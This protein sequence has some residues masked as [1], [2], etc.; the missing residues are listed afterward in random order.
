MLLIED[1]AGIVAQ[2]PRRHCRRWVKRP[3]K[4]MNRTSLPEC[5]AFFSPKRNRHAGF[6]GM[7]SSVCQTLGRHTVVHGGAK[8]AAAL[9]LLEK[10]RH[11]QPIRVAVALQEEILGV[12][13]LNA[14]HPHSGDFSRAVVAAAK[15]A[16]RAQDFE[17][18]IIAIGGRRLVLIWHSRP[19]RV[20]RV[21]AVE[22]MSPASAMAGSVRQAPVALSQTASSW[23]SSHSSQR[24]TS[25]SWISMSRKMPPDCLR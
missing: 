8:L 12:V 9:E 3:M 1:A 18:L 23:P 20:R 4:P 5:Q 24:N 7:R 11:F 22:S 14:V 19:L 15:Q 10:M 17:T 6:K 16:L 13:G 21:T 25:K 2:S